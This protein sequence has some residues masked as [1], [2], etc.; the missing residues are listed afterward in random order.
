VSAVARHL[1]EARVTG[2][3]AGLHAILRLQRPVDGLELVRAARQRSVGVYPLGYAY[4]Q[5]RPHDDGLVLG[6]AG[7]AEPAID[8]GIRRLAQALDECAPRRDDAQAPATAIL[9]RGRGASPRETNDGGAIA[10]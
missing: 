5:P 8:E 2:L 6:Y 3:A 4:M 1:P 9:E 7:L 10:R